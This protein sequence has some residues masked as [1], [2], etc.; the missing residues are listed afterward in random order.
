MIAPSVGDEGEDL[1]LEALADGRQLL[2]GN[3]NEALG[4]L[5]C[6]TKSNSLVGQAR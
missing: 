5:A 1:L 3:L 6:L 2:R 4:E